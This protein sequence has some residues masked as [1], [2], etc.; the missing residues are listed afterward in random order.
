MLKMFE[1][2]FSS[3]DIGKARKYYGEMCII[4]RYH[5]I[6]ARVL[7]GCFGEV[8]KVLF[9]LDDRMRKGLTCRSLRSKSTSS[10]R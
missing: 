2:K 1:R 10:S 4:D 3:H 5:E 6:N 9:S 7:W 8:D